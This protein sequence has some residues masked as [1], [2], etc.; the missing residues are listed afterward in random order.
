MRSYFRPEHGDDTPPALPNQ[1]RYQ[2]ARYQRQLQ[3]SMTP[4]NYPGKLVILFPDTPLVFDGNAGTTFELWL[5]A[6]VT[7]T[8]LKNLSP[9]I[10]YT[11]IIRQVGT[12]KHRFTWPANCYGGMTIDPKAGSVSTQTFVCKP[13]AGL[14]AIMPGGWA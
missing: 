8:S 6:S 7:A 3:Q 12:G 13:G 4:P 5:S 14:F 2:D 9:G 11:F 1:P 10:L